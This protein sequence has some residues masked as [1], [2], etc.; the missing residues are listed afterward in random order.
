[1]TIFTFT[2]RAPICDALDRQK[3]ELKV[4]RS[5]ADTLAWTVEGYPPSCR[6]RRG[7]APW[8]PL[9]QR[10][11]EPLPPDPA[12]ELEEEAQRIGKGERRG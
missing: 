10:G 1:M 12:R 11:D 8:A 2:L 6:N 7:G 9:A 3:E 5:I 4:K